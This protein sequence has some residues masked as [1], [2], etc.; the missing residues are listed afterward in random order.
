MLLTYALAL[1]A[2]QFVRKKKSPR[3]YTSMHSG[4]LE[5]AKLTYTM[6]EDNLIRH[7][8]DRGLIIQY[9]HTAVTRAAAT[10]PEFLLSPDIPT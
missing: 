8:D 9:K 5:L 1:P 6:L 4:G 7:R 10:T 3:T 2:R